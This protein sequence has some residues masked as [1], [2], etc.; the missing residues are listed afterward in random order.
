MVY[1]IKKDILKEEEKAHT[2]TPSTFLG[3]TQHH[4][5]HRHTIMIRIFIVCYII[6]I[7]LQPYRAKRGDTDI[8]NFKKNHMT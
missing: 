5:D 2:D 7:F 1:N 3:S 6:D 4:H 8:R